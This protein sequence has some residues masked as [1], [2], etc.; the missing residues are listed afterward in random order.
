MVVLRVVALAFPCLLFALPGVSGHAA[1]EG[2]SPD[3]F[4]IVVIEPL[5]GFSLVRITVDENLTAE[6]K[7]Q[8]FAMAD[9]YPEIDGVEAV[10]P[11]EARA[12]TQTTMRFWNDGLGMEKESLHM[13]P[14]SI[15]RTWKSIRP[16]YATT[17]RQVGHGFYDTTAS[18]P[19]EPVVFEDFETQKVREYSFHVMGALSEVTLYGA[20]PNATAKLGPVPDPQYEE[21]HYTIEYVVI[22]A[23]PGWRI[24]QVT[25]VTYTGPFV[26]TPNSERIDIA[27]FDTSQPWTIRFVNP[28]ADTNGG[29]AGSPGPG[30]VWLA[31]VVLVVALVNV[32]RKIRA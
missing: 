15:D 5:E 26:R 20:N 27:G 22:R 31:A 18:E 3:A 2:V 9:R 1:P 16:V 19:A 7:A 8:F 30:M 12:Y 13:T 6:A 25:G 28:D 21:V 29:A 4:C 17:W 11:D 24:A 32:R 10:S 23:P 14:G